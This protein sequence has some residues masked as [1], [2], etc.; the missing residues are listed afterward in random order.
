V[1]PSGD[2]GLGLKQ[3]PAERYDANHPTGGSNFNPQMRI[4]TSRAGS[5]GEE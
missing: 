1:P 5:I 4:D 3:T 2:L